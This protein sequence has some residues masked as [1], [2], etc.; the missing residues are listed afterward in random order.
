M[1]IYI[2]GSLEFEKYDINHLK[3]ELSYKEKVTKSQIRKPL[4]Y[5]NC[6]L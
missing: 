3:T 4:K 5:G 6:C 2:L 1:H